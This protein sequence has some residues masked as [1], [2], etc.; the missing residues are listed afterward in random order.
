MLPLLFRTV[1]LPLRPAHRPAHRLCRRRFISSSLVR[2]STLSPEPDAEPT[3]EESENTEHDEDEAEL[4]EEDE[5]AVEEKAPLP[6]SLSE[7]VRTIGKPL[8]HA[9]PRNWLGN[10]V[11]FPMNPSF[12]PPVPLSNAERSEMYRAFMADP[13]ANSVRAL[14]QKHGVSMK[15]IDAILRLKG[16]EEAWRKDNKRLQTGFQF[17]MERLLGVNTPVVDVFPDEQA[18]PEEHLSRRD[19]NEADTLEEMERRDAARQR[20]QRLYWESVPEDGREP[21]VPA[22][23]EQAKS[24][25]V[26][27]SKMKRTKLKRLPRIKD[28]ETIKSPRKRVQV[29]TKSGRPAIMFV[30]VGGQFMDDD[31]QKKRAAKRIAG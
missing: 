29:V 16:M 19:V 6:Q 3:N 9:S 24:L 8:K 2:C 14:S 13:K 18:T 26:L 7:F 25:A 15:R 12:R 27:F 11:P 10:G 17:G 5:S 30:D 28:T 31:E 22:S 21:I 4:V 20:Y 23:L 1:R